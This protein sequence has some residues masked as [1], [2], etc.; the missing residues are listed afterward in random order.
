M[1]DKV[2]QQAALRMGFDYA[3]DLPSAIEG[4]K[5]HK[6]NLTVNLIPAGGY[7][8]SLLTGGFR[9]MDT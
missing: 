6:E 4:T 7:I 9:L 8:C 1:A 5:M 2:L 3:L